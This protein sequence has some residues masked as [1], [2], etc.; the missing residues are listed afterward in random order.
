M[1]VSDVAAM[2]E[3][4]SYTYSDGTNMVCSNFVAGIW[5]A[6]GLFDNLDVNA[7]E[8]TPF[9]VYRVKFFDS[10]LKVPHSCERADP[11]QP[12]CQLLGKYRI[13]LPGFNEIEPYDRMFETC[14]GRNP[15][16]KYV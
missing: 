4:D 6:A 15:D 11:G 5:K 7:G 9:D 12:Y 16:Y 10:E 1:T 3:L 2:P 8:F 14:P 13:T